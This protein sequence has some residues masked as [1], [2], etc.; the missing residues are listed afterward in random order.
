MWW[1]SLVARGMIYLVRLLEKLE[2]EKTLVISKTG[3]KV[4]KYET[5]MTSEDLA[6]MADLV[7]EDDDLFS[8]ITSGSHKTDAMMN[9]SMFTIDIGKDRWGDSRYPDHPRA[10][11]VTIK[12]GRKLIIVPRETP[13]SA[14]MLENELRLARSGV[15]N[16]S[17]QVRVSITCPTPSM[18]L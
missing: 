2:G 18:I 16:L 15:V 6:G 17:P 5:C 7:L 8:V 3:K 14:I 13:L 1:P 11:A 12:E 4:L 9:T 10:A